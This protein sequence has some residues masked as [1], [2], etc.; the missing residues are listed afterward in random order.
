MNITL[1]EVAEKL[2]NADNIVITAHINPDGDAIGSS[3]GLMYLLQ[4]IGKKAEVYLNDDVP[5]IFSFLPGVEQIKKPAREVSKITPDLC[6]ILDTS[7]ERTGQVLASIDAPCVNIDHHKTNSGEEMPTYVSAERA[8]T[9]EIIY[10]LAELLRAD[11][12]E[13]AAVCLYTGLATDTGF[14]RY[15][16]CTPSTMRAGAELIAKGAKPHVISEAVE[17]KPY[18]QVLGM[19]RAMQTMELSF[20]GRVIGLY[21]D[22][23]LTA[24]LTETEGLV[25]MIRVVEGAEIAVLLRV[26]KENMCRVSMRSKGPDVAQIA[27]SLGGGG[28]TRAAG[29]TLNMPFAEAKRTILDAI[30]KALEQK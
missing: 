22:D 6:V 3:L 15:A 5:R 11:I 7:P 30:G 16:N 24:S 29:V 20:E 28:H 8:A 23:E 19:A 27:A 12:D 13:K 25:D 10:E 9:C 1:P 14:F 17:Q 18:E 2:L 26:P 4:N 21:L